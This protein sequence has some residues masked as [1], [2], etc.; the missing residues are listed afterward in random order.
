MCILSVRVRC[1][2]TVSGHCEGK[3]YNVSAFAQ[4]ET[5]TTV[6]V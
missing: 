6:K 5:N 1:S 2:T 4:R 3:T